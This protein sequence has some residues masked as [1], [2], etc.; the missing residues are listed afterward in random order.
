M[1][2]CHDK[3]RPYVAHVLGLAGPIIADMGYTEGEIGA[4]VKRARERA[5]ISQAELAKRIGKSLDAVKRIEYG[6]R[7]FQWTIVGQVAEAVGASP[8]ELL[9]FP[10]ASPEYLGM[11]L[12]PILAAFGHNPE[13]ADS[14][15]RILLEA[16]SA[17]Q[18]LP[19]DGPEELRYRMAGSLAAARSRG[20]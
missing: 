11:A 10:V 14:I 7:V 13:D 1:T 5:G 4:A 19:D 18:S 12:R 9:G 16:I 15:A 17:A 20:R 8:N 3:S 6:E 2:R